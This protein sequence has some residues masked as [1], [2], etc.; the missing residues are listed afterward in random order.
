MKKNIMLAKEFCY[1]C[2]SYGAESYIRGF[3]GYSL[4]LLIVY[5]KSF[6]NFGRNM[7]KVKDK[8]VIDIEK[9]YKNKGDV[10]INLNSSKTG[11]PIILIDPTF[12]QRNALAA[13]SQET[14]SRFKNHCAEFLKTPSLK[15]FEPKKTDIEKIIENSKKNRL[16]FALIEAKTNVQ[17]GDI[18]GS[19]LLKFYN[20]LS[21]EIS[22]Y[23]IIKNK[24]F[25][26]NGKESAR[27]FF[28]CKRKDKIVREGPFS[29][30]KENVKKFMSEHEK[31]FEKNG[32]I[33][34]TDEIKFNLKDFINKWKDKNNH[35]IGEM[36]IK[37]LK[38][39]KD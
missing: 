1:A 29:A 24:G 38:L 3:S 39:V 10:M 30:D 26:Y 21:K 25:N 20:Y 32:K 11:S 7:T 6:L 31:T 13:L 37:E 2:N 14:F 35:I 36:K 19:K 28:V 23:F 22:K 18:A 4:E 5:Y 9:H 8:L 27:Y 16:D 33:Y 12:K 17:E 34:A 15:S